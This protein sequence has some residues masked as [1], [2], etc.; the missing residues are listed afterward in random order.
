MPGLGAI[1]TFAIGTVPEASNVTFTLSAAAGSYAFTGGAASFAVLQASGA[2][3]Y[4]FTGSAATFLAQLSA[5]A[6]SYAETGAAAAFSIFEAA[7]GASYAESGS[8]ATFPIQ[9]AGLGTS[10]AVTGDAANVTVLEGDGPATYAVT[11]NAATFEIMFPVLGNQEFVVTGY[12]IVVDLTS[13]MMQLQMPINCI[14]AT[15]ALY[16][17]SGRTLERMPGKSSRKVAVFSG[18]GGRLGGEVSRFNVTT[19]SRGY[20]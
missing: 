8:A 2:A 6:A 14:M 20:D 9:F 1:G 19:G 13:A 4:A 11:G 17:R 12:P 3:G 15:D 7:N 10:Y 18:A 5:V 16:D